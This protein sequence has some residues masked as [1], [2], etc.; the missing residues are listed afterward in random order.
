MKAFYISV[1]QWH[2]CIFT[3]PGSFLEKSTHAFEKYIYV[4]FL[5]SSYNLG[6]FCSDVFEEYIKQGLFFSY[7]FV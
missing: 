2:L 3:A 4:G 1:M 7:K 6:K 5:L